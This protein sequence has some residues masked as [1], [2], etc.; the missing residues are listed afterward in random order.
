MYIKQLEVG[1]IGV[2][3]IRWANTVNGTVVTQPTTTR[4]RA[5]NFVV[6]YNAAVNRKGRD[7]NVKLDK[8]THSTV[9]SGKYVH[10]YVLVQCLSL[11]LSLSL[12]LCS[13]SHST[14]QPKRVGQTR[15][16]APEKRENRDIYIFGVLIF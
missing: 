1:A 11:S 8:R 9:I 13:P 4:E 3:P 12:S 16:L 6:K 10:R 14:V 15:C 5:R 2:A 7:T